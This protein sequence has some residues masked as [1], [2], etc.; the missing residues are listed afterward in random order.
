MSAPRLVRGLETDASGTFVTIEWDAGTDRG[1]ALPASYFREVTLAKDG[2]RLPDG[3][4]P[5]NAFV[6]DVRAT[7]DRQIIVRFTGLDALWSSG[8]G[9]A[10]AGDAGAQPERRLAFVL[11]FPDRAKHIDCTHPGMNDEYF[12]T[13]TLT[14]SDPNHLATSTFEQRVSVGAV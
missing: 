2:V 14:F 4:P 6:A 5:G 11:Q 13:V 10:S 12:L 7:G 9:G 3:T 1:A 8:D